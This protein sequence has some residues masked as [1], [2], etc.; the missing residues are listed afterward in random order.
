[1]TDIE[2]LPTDDLLAELFRRHDHAVFTGMQ[3][4]TADDGPVTEV[5]VM[6]D[7]K[8][9]AHATA[10]LALHTAIR[11]LLKFDANCREE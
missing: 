10:G 7:W 4:R 2:L 6:R 5:E 3:K 1:M 9:N 11:I 8:G